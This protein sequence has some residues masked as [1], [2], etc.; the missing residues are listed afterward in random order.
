MSR[1]SPAS[2]IRIPHRARSSA[3]TISPAARLCYRSLHATG[4]G[5]VANG[6]LLDVLRRIAAFGLTL[7]RLDV[8]QEANRHT[9]AL[10][11]ITLHQGLGLYADWSEPDRVAFLVRALEGDRPSIP[12]DLRPDAEV[13]EVLATFRAIGRIPA[14]SLGAYVLRWRRSRPT[15]SQSSSCSGRPAWPGRFAWCRCSKPR[16]ISRRPAA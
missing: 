5:I 14:E 13:A 11:A 3:S 8:R 7:V 10:N 15:S 1:A 2:A 4:N 16:A 9:D 6:R 12:A